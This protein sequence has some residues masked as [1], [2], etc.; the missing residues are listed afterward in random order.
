MP[1]HFG[2]VAS[3]MLDLILYPSVFGAY[4]EIYGGLSKEL[5]KE[6]DQGVFISPWGRKN[7]VRPDVAAEIGE[8]GNAQKLFD[9]CEQQTKKYA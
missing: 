1:G 7:V 6:T 3:K 4:T 8:G 5:K 9:W 2:A